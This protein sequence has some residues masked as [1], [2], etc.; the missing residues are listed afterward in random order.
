MIRDKKY[1]EAE[2]VKHEAEELQ[3]RDKQLRH[4]KANHKKK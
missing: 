2:T 3:R 4:A 1:D